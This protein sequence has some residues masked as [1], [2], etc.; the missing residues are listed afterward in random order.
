VLNQS[1]S[2][3]QGGRAYLAADLER[4]LR[5]AQ[6]LA[7]VPLRQS[8][9][10]DA[11]CVAGPFL[12]VRGACDERLMGPSDTSE[13]MGKCPL[14]IQSGAVARRRGGAGV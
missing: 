8:Q 13:M 14:A 6:R 1:H 3:S 5:A 10:G 11:A 12:D 4:G 2:G 9:P 7:E